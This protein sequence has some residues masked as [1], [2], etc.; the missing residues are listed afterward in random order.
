M[1]DATLAAQNGKAVYPSIKMGTPCRAPRHKS[2][3]HH[4]K[5]SRHDT[6]Q[7]LAD[8][9]IGRLCRASGVGAPEAPTPSLP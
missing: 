3:K 5:T 2:R 4:K 6:L 9:A 7:K 1:T 8:V